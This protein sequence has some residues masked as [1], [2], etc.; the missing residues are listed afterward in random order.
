MVLEV[1]AVWKVAMDK[2][3]FTAVININPST[4]ICM[5]DRNLSWFSRRD[6]FQCRRLPMFDRS[7]RDVG[8]RGEFRRRRYELVPVLDFLVDHKFGSDGRLTLTD[9]I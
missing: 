1:D 5:N 4:K 6:S 2:V 7:L 3:E 8:R 9:S